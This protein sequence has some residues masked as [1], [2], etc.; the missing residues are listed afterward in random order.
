[1]EEQDVASLL[2]SDVSANLTILQLGGFALTIILALAG[3]LLAIRSY[4]VLSEARSLYWQAHAIGTTKAIQN[5]LR[6]ASPAAIQKAHSKRKL[7]S[8]RLRGLM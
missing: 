1:M 7:K 8:N 6:V 3:V 2:A 5:V 4:A